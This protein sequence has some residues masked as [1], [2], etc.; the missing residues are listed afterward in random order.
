MLEPVSPRTYA[1]IQELTRSTVLGDRT[2]EYCP[3]RVLPE[4]VLS[5][6]NVVRDIERLWDESLG[7]EAAAQLRATPEGG[8][9]FAGDVRLV[10]VQEGRPEMIA[11]WLPIPPDYPRRL[12]IQLVDT[13]E[14]FEF[15]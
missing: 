5:L 11:V 7:E 3:C 13:V 10:A 1:R 14:P 8:A 6:K 4:T 15:P 9:F 2:I 12:R